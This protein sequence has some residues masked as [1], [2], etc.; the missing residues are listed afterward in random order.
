MDLNFAT[1]INI[2]Y[3]KIDRE[4]IVAVVRD[5]TERK[6]I[7]KELIA[8]KEKA[9]E[10]DRLKSAFLAN[11][12]HEIRT[13]MNGILGFTGL[14]KTPMLTGEKQLQYIDIIEK[15][16]VRMLNIINDIISISKVEAGQTEII[17]SDISINELI[18]YIYNFFR[19]EAEQKKLLVFFKN[20][21]PENEAIIRTDREKVIAV[22]TN[23]VKN[24]IKFTFTGSIEFGYNK[25]G[26]FLEFYVK[27]T[28]IGIPPEQHE[29]IFDRFR[30]GSESLT[31]NFEGSG[32][33]LSISKAYVK[34]LG[35][36]IWVENNSDSHLPT[37]IIQFHTSTVS[38]RKRLHI[39]F[40]SS[41]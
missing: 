20:S 8:A 25:T 13:P 27:D 19:P 6:R 5:I 14:L 9:E 32:L 41:L 18:T 10:S 28:G 37:V 31:R 11:M 22:L 1:E 26:N 30:Q 4:Y 17:L 23:L 39:L 29:F 34:K 24:A 35:G 2:K 3:V 40:Y 38:E 7:D 16:G 36:K 15:S 21:L 12:S 33:G